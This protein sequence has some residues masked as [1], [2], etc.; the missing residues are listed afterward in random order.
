MS[1]ESKTIITDRVK[2]VTLLQTP[3]NDK[4]FLL[5]FKIVN[6]GSKIIQTG[7]ASVNVL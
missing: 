4:I 7:S 5:H 3:E 6:Y 1:Q 2:H